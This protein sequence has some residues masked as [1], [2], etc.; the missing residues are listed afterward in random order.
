MTHPD[1]HY[2]YPYVFREGADIFLV[3]ESYDADAVDL[4][5]CVRFPNEW[6]HHRTL[7]MGR[8]VDTSIWCEHGRWWMMTTIADPH[9]RATR[10][11][12]FFSDSLTGPWQLHPANPI[13]TDARNNRGAG[14]IFSV[15]G[16]WIRPSQSA[17]PT[18]GYSFDL[19]E[20]TELTSERYSERTIKTVT[21]EYAPG[22]CGI[23]TYSWIPGLELIDGVVRTPSK[24]VLLPE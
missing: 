19:N 20:I 18:Y 23:H 1:Q 4:Y 14:R 12:L 24:N 6:A 2:S 9:P 21:P 5:R 8:F 3:P 10:L 16:R 11:L 22:L 7:L 17:S 15:G 13:S